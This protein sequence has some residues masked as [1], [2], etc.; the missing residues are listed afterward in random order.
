MA[1]V[2]IALK[3]IN[4]FTQAAPVEILLKT[5]HVF[6]QAVPKIREFRSVTMGFYG[7][8]CDATADWAQADIISWI[9]V[10]SAVRE[11]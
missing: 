7:V 3:T 1:K 4:I 2:A 8:I 9:E 6:T 5:I 10:M 11:S